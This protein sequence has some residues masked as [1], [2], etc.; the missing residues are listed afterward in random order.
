M[1]GGAPPSRDVGEVGH[2]AVHRATKS[3][4]GADLQEMMEED[5]LGVL[6]GDRGTWSH[7]S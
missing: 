7:H 6:I 5:N 2:K 3:G 4:I 1:A